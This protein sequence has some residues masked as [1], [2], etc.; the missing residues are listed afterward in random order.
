MTTA[1]HPVPGLV[2][3][4]SQ[5]GFVAGGVGIALCA[6]GLLVS[7]V[8]TLRSYLFAFLF[9][10]GVPVGCLSLLLIQ[11]LTGGRWGLVMRRVLEAGARTL[12]FVAL[13]FLPIVIGVPRLYEWADAARVAADPVLTHKAAYL[14]PA[15]FA[16]RAVFYFAIW[17]ALAHFLSA[18]SLRLDAGPDRRLERRLRG[19]SGGGLVLLGL[20]ITFSS[21]DWGMSLDA[22]WASTIYG[23]LF[24]VGQVLAAFTLAIVTIAALGDEE[25][26]RRVVQRDTTHDF[27]KLLFAFV[28]LWAYVHLSQ[29]LIVWSAN[30]PEEIPW[31]LR[32]TRNG[33][34]YVAWIVIIV[35][36]IAPF[37]ALLSRDL[38]RNRKRLGTVAAV[39]FAAR[40]VDLFWVVAPSLDR[41]ELTV[42]WTDVAAVV[43]L[44]G[45]WLGLFTREL[46]GRS[47]VPLNQPELGLE[48][49][50]A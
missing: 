33:W 1:T 10:G 50:H 17:N 28:M 2:R 21:I 13:G 44:G 9:W 3:R 11:N 18:W 16:V 12:P 20:T 15:F 48:A 6:V 34:L 5:R 14:N 25:P 36:F 40:L 46:A 7:P 32:R 8:E 49:E 24:M 31:Y 42:H 19:L 41:P 29:F 4:V 38:K 35:H 23:I 39:V 27:G 37:F 45:L 47:L 30:L 26:F 22:H 43:G